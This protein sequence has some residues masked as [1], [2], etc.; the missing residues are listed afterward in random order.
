[1]PNPSSQPCTTTPPPPTITFFTHS[2]KT[3]R[4]VANGFPI[5]Q[6]PF[7]CVLDMLG[8]LYI[9]RGAFYLSLNAIV[10]KRAFY[11]RF[12]VFLRLRPSVQYAPRH[13]NTGVHFPVFLSGHLYKVD[14][15]CAAQNSGQNSPSD[16]CAGT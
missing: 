12:R 2:Y 13:G 1:M 15:T 14:I 7:I 9:F 16:S 4:A 11:L 6:W 8:D 3:K 5:L 10:L